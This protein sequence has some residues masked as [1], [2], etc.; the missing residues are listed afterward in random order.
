MNPNSD[1]PLAGKVALVTGGGRGLG[2]AICAALVQ[3][4]AHVAVADI[5]LTSAETMCAKLGGGPGKAVPIELD[6]GNPGNVDAAIRKVEEALGPI[7]ILVNNAGIDHTLSVE[8]LSIDQWE[9]VIAT[10][11]SGPFLLSKAALKRMHEKRSGHIV[12]I[13]STAAKRTWPNAAA[14]HASKWGLL[15]L[16]HAMHA[17]LRPQGIKVTA[18]ITGGMRTPFLLDRF[19]DINVETLQPPE[20]VASAVLQVLL[21]PGDSVIPEI[22]VLP[23]RETSWP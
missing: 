15:G 17:E 4:G 18:V 12:N 23:M 2:A 7:D 22:T 14:Y 9:D 11:L 5:L 6:V 20:V 19:P 10:N 8:E 16:S 13:A 3:A 21:L 1:K